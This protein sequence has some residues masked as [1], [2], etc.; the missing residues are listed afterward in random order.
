MQSSQCTS[1]N[2][3]LV[4][5]RSLYNWLELESH[6]LRLRALLLLDTLASIRCGWMKQKCRVSLLLY[7]GISYHSHA[8]ADMPVTSVYVVV[9]TNLHHY[10]SN[11]NVKDATESPNIDGEACKSISLAPSI[12][13]QKV[14]SIV[15]TELYS[16]K[17]LPR[18]VVGSRLV[19]AP[20]R[21]TLLTL[22]LRH[23][24]Q[25]SKIEVDIYCWCCLDGWK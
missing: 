13:V 25:E 6:I 7:D 2:E 4:P 8:D 20:T 9:G 24:F 14:T 12:R 5:R 3:A 16:E 23:I 21:L 22:T 19:P 10:W 11:C 18:V 15:L 17:P 1:A